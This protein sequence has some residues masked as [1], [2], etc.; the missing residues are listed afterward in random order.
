MRS[1]GFPGELVHSFAY[2]DFACFQCFNLNFIIMNDNPYA[3]KRLW[4]SS[5]SDLDE[6]INTFFE[7]TPFMSIRNV[8]YFTE[9]KVNS[10]GIVSASY[11]VLIIYR[12]VSAFD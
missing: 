7:L 10:V 8:S 5:L 4:A 11:S 12:P 1:S 3:C 2:S 9:Q 6:Q